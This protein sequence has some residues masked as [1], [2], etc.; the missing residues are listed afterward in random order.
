MTLQSLPE[1]RPGHDHILT[2]GLSVVVHD[3]L[4]AVEATWRRMEAAP[5]ASLHNGYDW[6]GA[7]IASQGSS[8]LIIEGRLDGRTIFLLPL[9]IEHG[10]LARV[11]R[12]IASDFSNINTGLFEPGLGQIDPATLR[13]ALVAAISDR[14]DVLSLENMPLQWRG[15]THALSGLDRT[16][17]QNRAFQMPLQSSFEETLKQVNAKR[18]RKKFRLQQKRFE[19]IGGWEVVEPETAEER[20]ALMS[21]FFRQKAERF[22]SQGLPD[23]FREK[24]VQDFFHALLDLATSGT[25]YPLRLRALTLKGEHEGTIVAIAGLSRKGDHVICQFGSIREDLFPET[26]PGEFLFWHLIEQSCVSG[27]AIFDFGVG[28]QLYKRSWCS[29]ETVQYDILVPLTVRGRLAA[30]YHRAKVRLKAAIKRNRHLYARIQ[31]LR[32]GSGKATRPVTAR[33]E[34]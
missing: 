5:L 34:D 30:G 33:D 7:W 6:C 25:S 26:S 22:E 27:A 29:V 9:E 19:E 14:V 3:R 23:V 24:Q 16:E 1:A 8:P 13:E 21:E 11:A 2:R 20:H 18:R 31:R 12:F 28:D 4:D 15:E 17:N 32:A 10:P